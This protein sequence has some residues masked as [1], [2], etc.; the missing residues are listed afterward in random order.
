[1]LHLTYCS[2]AAV[3]TFIIWWY[4]LE[5]Q[6]SSTWRGLVGE[7]FS[8]MHRLAEQLWSCRRVGLLMCNLT[9]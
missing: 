9:N 1:M 2:S 3:C 4:L 6:S 8:C 7:N 5:E